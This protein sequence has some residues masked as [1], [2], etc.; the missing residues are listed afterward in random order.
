MKKPWIAGGA[1]V[2]LILISTFLYIQQ[3][4]ES[5]EF[6]RIAHLES[7]TF[8]NTQEW[9]KE[10]YDRQQAGIFYLNQVERNSITLPLPPTN[11][12]EVTKQE[13]QELLNLIENR[14]L[15]KINEINQELELRNF[16]FNSQTLGTLSEDKLYTTLL[17]SQAL[18]AFDSIIIEKKEYF[19]R[20]RPS[21]LDTTLTT[22]ID[23]P[24][25]PSYPSGHASQA[26][27]LALILGDLDS[28]NSDIYIED[29]HSIAHNRE[30]AGVHYKSDSEAGRILAR[31]YHKL[32][33]LNQEYNNL[34]NQA[35]A[36]W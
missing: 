14:T 20:V 9:D 12:S 19:D 26:M 13:I 21:L 29:A 15:E 16:T 7:L 1:L 6:E 22:V 33:S 30:I 31:E 32:I 35:R 34:L 11:T 17:L 24:G 4:Q 25:H 18:I 36:E 2:A 23:V 10:I 5:K 28:E 27:F 3:I 8:S